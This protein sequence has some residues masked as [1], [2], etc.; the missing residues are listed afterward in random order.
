MDADDT[1]AYVRFDLDNVIHTKGGNPYK[2]TGQRIFVVTI[3]KMKESKSFVGHD[4][5]P[6]CGSKI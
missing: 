6:F 3:G 2:H 5:C 4:Y 1:I